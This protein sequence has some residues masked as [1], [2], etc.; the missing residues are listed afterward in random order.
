LDKL[1]HCTGHA[2]RLK[3]DMSGHF[4]NHSYSFEELIAEMG[5]AY[6]CG[7]CGI[8]NETID[9]SAAY[10]QGWLSKLKSDNKFFV[11]AASKAQHAVDYITQAQ[12]ETVETETVQPEHETE[13]IHSF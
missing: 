9:N 7:L 8:E 13:S 6:L 4:G 12:F 1:C 2:K 10:I 5:A 11:L 3:R